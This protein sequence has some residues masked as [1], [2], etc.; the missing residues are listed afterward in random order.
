MQEARLIGNVAS[1][2]YAKLGSDDQIDSWTA[3]ANGSLWKLSGKALD[4][5]RKDKDGAYVITFGGNHLFPF[6]ETLLSFH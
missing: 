3:C 6:Q 4:N 1:S 5:R 2:A